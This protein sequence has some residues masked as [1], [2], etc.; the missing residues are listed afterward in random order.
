MPVSGGYEIRKMKIYS[1]K[2]SERPL[3]NPHSLRAI[4]SSCTIAST[5]AFSWRILQRLFLLTLT[6][7]MGVL[8]QVVTIV[9]VVGS[10]S[11]A[12]GIQEV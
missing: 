8:V 6:G 12:R 9:W 3:L 10:G 7:Y 11:C 1:R 5:P 4:L 2:E